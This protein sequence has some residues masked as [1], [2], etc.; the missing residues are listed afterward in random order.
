MNRDTIIVSVCMITYNHEPYIAEAI[1]GVLMQ[2]TNFQIE[3]I[4]GEDCSTDRT[5]EI[6]KIYKEKYPD[7]IKLRL[8]ENNLGV[9]PNF[10]ENLQACTGKYIAICEGDDYWTN[11]LKLQK[12]VDLLEADP[13][14]SGS[15]HGCTMIYIS[16]RKEKQ[17]VYKYL[18]R[19]ELSWF[20][21]N[22]IFITTGSLLFRTNILEKAPYFANE[23]FA[24]DTLL[25]YLMLSSGD[26][27]YIPEV[28][29]VYRKGS[30]GSWSNR[31]ITPK[32]VNKEFSDNLR[33]LYYI[34]EMTEYTYHAE[35]QWKT[36]NL[37][38]VYVKYSIP[39]NKFGVNIKNFF[40]AFPFL[41]FRVNGAFLRDIFKSI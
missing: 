20:L 14:L 33:T 32:I 36:K 27:G 3:L 2:K 10:I 13:S 4:V 38:A 9:M 34:D 11:P 19:I 6:C 41:P 35:V 37:I 1:E 30:I 29:S 7:L 23:L 16:G 8:P 25:K 22:G 28:M 18:N 21:K 5:R 26:I 15:S 39:F 17:F 40:Y 12:Q 24:G 31:K